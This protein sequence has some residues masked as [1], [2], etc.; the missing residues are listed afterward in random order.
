[1]PYPNST[2]PKSIQLILYNYSAVSMRWN[3][4][5]VKV[6]LLTIMFMLLGLGREANMHASGPKGHLRTQ[7]HCE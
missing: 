4:N 6:S 1:M 2:F 5:S 7:T 3:T